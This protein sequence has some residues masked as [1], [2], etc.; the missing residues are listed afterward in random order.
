MIM[1]PEILN[2]ANIN[3]AVVPQYVTNSLTRSPVV[4]MTNSVKA[5]H[6]IILIKNNPSYSFNVIS[7]IP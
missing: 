2:I 1:S 4:P 5:I 3:V 6:L 7:P